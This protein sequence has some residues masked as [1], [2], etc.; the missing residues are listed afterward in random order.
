MNH[1]LEAIP[2]CP[3]CLNPWIPYFVKSLW[4]LKPGEKPFIPMCTFCITGG[5]HRYNAPVAMS[6]AKL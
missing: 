1:Y 5:N 2:K 4:E 6:R 3:S